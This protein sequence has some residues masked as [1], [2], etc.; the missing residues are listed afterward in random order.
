MEPKTRPTKA[1]MA[2]RV[3]PSNSARSS[4]VCRDWEGIK[5]GPFLGAENRPV[6]AQAKERAGQTLGEGQGADQGIIEGKSF[7]RDSGGRVPR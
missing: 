5:A 4:V 6:E 3:V 2:A 7:R 1:A